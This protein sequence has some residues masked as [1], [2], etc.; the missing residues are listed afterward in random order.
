MFVLCQLLAVWMLADWKGSGEPGSCQLVEL[1]PGRGTL[2]KDMLRVRCLCGVRILRNVV[3]S[4]RGIVWAEC[5]TFLH[6]VMVNR[7]KCH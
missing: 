1:G 4:Q 5:D 7:L 3:V 6:L 2:I